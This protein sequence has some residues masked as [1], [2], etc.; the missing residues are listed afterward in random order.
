MSDTCIDCDGL[1]RYPS[2]AVCK[3][4]EG[5]GRVQ[6]GDGERTSTE[7]GLG[8]WT[9]HEWPEKGETW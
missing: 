8:K 4:C 2:G 5:S 3:S 9:V 6:K 1:G 7:G